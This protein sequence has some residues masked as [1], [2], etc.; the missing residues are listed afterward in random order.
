MAKAF[1]RSKDYGNPE[2]FYE[3]TRKPLRTVQEI[4][5]DI[6]RTEHFA[7]VLKAQGCGRIEDGPNFGFRY[8]ERELVPART[9]SP[10]QYPNGEG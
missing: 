9:T 6:E 8:V 10:A 5:V 3:T 2:P 1:R 7:A 4:P